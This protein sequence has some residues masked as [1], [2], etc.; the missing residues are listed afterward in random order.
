MGLYIFENLRRCPLN[1]GHRVNYSK[2]IDAASQAKPFGRFLDTN[3]PLFF[4]TEDPI[5]SVKQFLASTAQK[6]IR[7]WA[8]V[9]RTLLEGLAFGYR[10]TID[11]LREITKNT[12]RRICVVGGG[13]RNKLLCQMTAD[14]TGLEV[15]AGPAEATAAGNLAAQALATGALGKSSDIR[16]V[17]QSSFNLKRYKPH[18]T[19]LWE[20]NY[21][22]Y[23]EALGGASGP[24]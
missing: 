17:I 4:A 24:E 23:K 9:G 15:I 22:R 18:S 10:Q 21:V 14:A 12:F 2:M 16:R 8:Q 1:Q 11:D 13:N 7:S 19:Q 5:L 20:R 6:G 3:S